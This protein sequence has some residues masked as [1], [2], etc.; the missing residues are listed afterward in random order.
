MA[1]FLQNV[2][3]A[4]NDIISFP[5]GIPGFKTMKR[6][7]IVNV[8]EYAPF[9]WMVSV[10]DKHLR[11]AVVNPM[12]FAPDY[13]PNMRKEQLSALG[14]EKPEDILIYVI[15]TIRENPLESTANL[16]GPILINKTRR[17][18]EQIILE[19]DR[20]TTQEPILRKK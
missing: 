13:S 9:E 10:D 14:I 20:Y 18:A 7:V 8:P 5:A 2:V 17:I 6:F 16:S 11:F 1:A 12:L 19:D 15:V 4:E 3:F